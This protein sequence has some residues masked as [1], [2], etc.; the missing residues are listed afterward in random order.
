MK[1]IVE[2]VQNGQM[3]QINGKTYKAIFAIE[4]SVATLLRVVSMTDN[5]AKYES[6]TFPLGTEIIAY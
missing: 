2:L 4:T 3:L 6:L 5:G 1:T